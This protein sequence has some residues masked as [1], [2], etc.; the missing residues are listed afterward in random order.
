MN[1]L[2]SLGAGSNGVLNYDVIDKLKKADENAQIT[3]IDK[4]LQTNIEKQ[5]E[6]AGLKTMLS[7]LKGS[8]DKLADYSSYMNRN[9][10]SSNENVLKVSAGAGVPVQNINIK[11]DSI[12]KNSVNEVGLKFSSRDSI[13]SKHNTTIKFNINGKDFKVRVSNN[14]TLEEV[15]QKIID[16]TDGLI[17]ASIMKMVEV[18]RWSGSGGGR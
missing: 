11:I 3:P 6:L 1:P 15:A 7:S 13:F 10:S 9:V 16:N 17:N 5:S 14:D 18:A 2:S 12:A 4:K 8:A